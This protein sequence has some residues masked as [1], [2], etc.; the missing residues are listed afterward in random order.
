M[1]GP[2]GATRPPQ[3]LGAGPRWGV[4]LPWCPP[5]SPSPPGSPGQQRSPTSPTQPVAEVEG[6][7][8]GQGPGPLKAETVHGAV[9]QTLLK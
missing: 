5:G 1:P 8:S 2:P 9:S 4:R 7:R 3:G 6:G